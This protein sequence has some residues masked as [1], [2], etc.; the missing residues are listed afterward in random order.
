MFDLHEH[1]VQANTF[2]LQ[3]SVLREVLGEDAET[4][5]RKLSY[6]QG[7]KCIDRQSQ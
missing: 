2:E 3:A 5:Q 1:R 6:V 7:T 4:G